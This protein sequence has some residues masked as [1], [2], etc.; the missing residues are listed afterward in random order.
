VNAS[1]IKIWLISVALLVGAAL[2]FADRKGPDK[3]SGEIPSSSVAK[4]KAITVDWISYCDSVIASPALANHPELKK[5]YAAIHAEKVDSSV[6]D[7]VANILLKS[8]SPLAAA[9]VYLLKAQA[10][11]MAGDWAIEAESFYRA[12]RFTKGNLST[13]AMQEAV[14]GFRKASELAPKNLKFKT[15]LGSAIVESSPNPMEGITL[16]REVVAQDSTFVDAQVQL[17][18]FAVQ[19][20]QFDKAI[21][22]LQKVIKMRP[23]F[24][25]AYLYLGQAYQ[26]S[27]NIPQ[28][29]E[30]LEK[31]RNEINDP[32]LRDEVQK[33]IEQLK[34]PSNS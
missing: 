20:G 25:V 17:A 28:A 33:Y 9:T 1:R 7:S 12:S 3:V 21:N 19:S 11:S 29:I 26:Q 23:D 22:R 15:L 27:G 16:L 2:W 18:L 14:S 5:M 13:A 24:F 6:Y 10:T 8:Q 34:K 32:A 30:S 4:N 31:Y